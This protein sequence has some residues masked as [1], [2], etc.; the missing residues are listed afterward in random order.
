MKREE[1]RVTREDEIIELRRRGLATWGE[2]QELFEIRRRKALRD[3]HR[4]RGAKKSA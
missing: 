4:E 1:D 2:H 3:L